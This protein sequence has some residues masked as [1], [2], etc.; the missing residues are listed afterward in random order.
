MMSGTS[1]PFSATTKHP[2]NMPVTAPKGG[3]EQVQHEASRVFQEAA[4][5]E[6]EF[7]EERDVFSAFC[8]K[9]RHWN[10]NVEPLAMN[11]IKKEPQRRRPADPSQSEY[12]E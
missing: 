8:R 6:S 9:K 5:K 10:R 11:S 4:G 3:E 7:K 2:T 12:P 1:P